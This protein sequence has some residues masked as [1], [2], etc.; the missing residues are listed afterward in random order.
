[1]FT[2]KPV[3]SRSGCCT[4]QPKGKV[5][6]P[7]CHEKAK[8]VLVKTLEHLLHAESK[9]KLACLD[10]F[11]YCKT[12]SCEVVYFKDEEILT[13]NDVSITVGLKDGAM[14]ATVCYCF[15]WT[16]E[17]IA[18]ELKATGTTN[19][20]DDIKAKMENPG[21]SCE[22]LNPSG[23]CCLGDVAKVIKEMKETL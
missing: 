22:I 2:V 6:C 14:P 3:N 15:E 13:Q 7:K 16:K 23:G 17:K 1:M 12:P 4:P 5:A 11:Y 9:E 21:C 20:L 10:G 8:G 18:E 19:A